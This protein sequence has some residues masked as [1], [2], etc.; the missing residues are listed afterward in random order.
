MY[1]IKTASKHKKHLQQKFKE[2]IETLTLNSKKV[3]LQ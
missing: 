1:K 3:T 2:F